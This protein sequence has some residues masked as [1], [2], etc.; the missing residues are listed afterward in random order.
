[1]PALG[2]LP[3]G[4]PP[5]PDR[6]ALQAPP[7]GRVLERRRAG[8]LIADPHPYL[9][10]P[11]WHAD[12]PGRPVAFAHRGGTSVA[13]ENSL[14]AFEHAWALGYRYLETDVHLTSD[15]ALVAFH[16]PDLRRTCG[17]DGTIA[18]L[19][20]A[21]IAEARVGGTDRIPLM[22]DLLERFPEAHFNIDAKSDAAVDPLCDLVA[23]LGARDRVCLASFDL[24]RIRRMSQR[25]AGRVMTN[26]SP[27]EIA[28]LRFVGRLPGRRPRSA[29]VPPRRSVVDIV[30]PRFLTSSHRAG[31]AVHV[32]TI[33][34]RR[35]MERLL[36]LGVDGIMT[37]DTELLREVFVAR[38]LWPD[39]LR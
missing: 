13:P 7:E 38:D 19:T 28:T 17:I 22:S 33:D 5:P 12:D 8:D 4:T 30:A 14:A 37:D 1:M 3:R 36:D 34:D 27:T 18:Q 26:M 2:R 21:Q 29:Q 15:G 9:R 39:E 11:E 16:D 23:S 10:H 31:I 20:A 24:R 6:Q 32:W 25:F 35:E